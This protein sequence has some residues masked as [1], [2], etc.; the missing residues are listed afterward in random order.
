ME[1]PIQT[2]PEKIEDIV[3]ERHIFNGPQGDGI[4]NYFYRMNGTELEYRREVIGPVPFE[5]FDWTP[6]PDVDQVIDGV[7]TTVKHPYKDQFFP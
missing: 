6:I 7:T 2:L 1:Q 4:I 5:G 3:Y